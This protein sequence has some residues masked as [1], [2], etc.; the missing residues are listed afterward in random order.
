[1]T[2]Q[3]FLIELEKL[4]IRLTE[5]QKDQLNQYFELLINWNQKINLTSIVNKNEV[6]LKHYYDSA[7][8][9]KIIDLNKPYSLCDIGSG[10]GFPGMILKILFPNLK[11]TLVDSLKKRIVF[12]QEVIHELNLKDIQAVHSRAEEYAKEHIEKFDIVTARAVAHLNILLELAIP[13]IKNQGY[14]IAMK[15]NVEEELKESKNALKILN[16]K[17][18]DKIEFILPIENSKRT[19][20][21]IEKLKTCP[22]K[23]PRKYSDIKKN[24]L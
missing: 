24:R 7:T 10:A 22:G 21:K 11:I 3:E 23:Y 5:T 9:V 13:M 8:I 4:N 12:L 18:N 19:L 17:I 1:M 20:I 6:Y 15:A 16:S 14:F 2:E